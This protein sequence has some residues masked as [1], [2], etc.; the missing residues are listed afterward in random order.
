[1]TK[2]LVV[3]D[4]ALMR[5]LLGRI[6]SK[7]ADFD[8]QFA[9]NGLEALE[10]LAVFKPD[11]VTLDIHMPQMDGLA[12][13]D[14]IMIERPC[15]VVMVSSLTAEGAE[16]TLQALRL[17]AIDFVAKPEGAISLHIDELTDELITKVRAASTARMRSS[18]RLRERVRH[19]IGRDAPAI[20]LEEGDRETGRRDSREPRRAVGEGLVV[21]GTSTG[22]PPAL[23]ALLTVLPGDFRWPIVVAQHMPATF[24]GALARRLNGVSALSV[25]EVVRTMQLEP[26]CAYIG[27][28]DADLVIDRRPSGVVVAPVR[29]QADYPWHPSTDRLV[30]SAMDHVSP[31][32]IVGVLMTGMGSDGAE[33][34]AQLRARGGRTIAEAEETAVV[35]GMPGELVAAGG[36]DWVLPL[37]AIAGWLTKLVP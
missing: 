16:V 3:D 14:R 19:R 25:V 34:M 21:V 10:L 20:R 8:V 31:G 24:T 6:F 5:K 4:S 33:A 30:R 2:V 32:Q 7:E 15:P 27:K 22:G 9:R 37:P 29:S 36:A 12:C 17:G 1:M 26:G 23:E 35:W 28:G 11:V 18:A 13:L